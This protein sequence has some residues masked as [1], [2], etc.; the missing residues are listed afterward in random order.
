MTGHS[1]MSGVSRC[2]FIIGRRCSY[3]LTLA[4]YAGSSA[5]VPSARSRSEYCSIV[6]TY[7][8]ISVIDTNEYVLSNA[9]PSFDARIPCSTASIFSG[10]ES[11]SISPRSAR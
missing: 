10:S 2:L 3:A 6:G 7:S 1:G 4:K 8:E 11:I 5:A 9:T